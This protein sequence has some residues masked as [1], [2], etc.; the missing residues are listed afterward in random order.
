MEV[1]PRFVTCL[2]IF[3]QPFYDSLNAGILGNIYHK[4]K[5]RFEPKLLVSRPCLGVEYLNC[6]MATKEKK[7]NSIT[8]N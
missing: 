7:L 1:P 8:G 3:Q 2:K 6:T 4:E 5:L